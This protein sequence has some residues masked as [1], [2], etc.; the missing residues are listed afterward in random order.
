MAIRANTRHEHN[1]GRISPAVGR[2]GSETKQIDE[3]HQLHLGLCEGGGWQEKY[4]QKQNHFILTFIPVNFTQSYGKK[5]LI[6]N[7]FRQKQ[8]AWTNIKYWET[9]SNVISCSYQEMT[10]Q[11]RLSFVNEYE[12]FSPERLWKWSRLK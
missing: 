1:T 11:V 3:E 4:I 12:G 9:A 5:I 7:Q 6:L 10:E 8:S 2:G